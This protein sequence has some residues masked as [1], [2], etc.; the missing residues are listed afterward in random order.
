MRRLDGNGTGK[1]LKKCVNILLMNTITVEMKETDGDGQRRN[2]K[3]KTK[4]N[5]GAWSGASDCK[6]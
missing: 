6:G 1:N 4:L 5:G 2:K 3:R